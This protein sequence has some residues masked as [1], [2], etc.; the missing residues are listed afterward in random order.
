MTN[1][2][3]LQRAVKDI[4][5]VQSDA[6]ISASPF[7]LLEDALRA[8]REAAGFVLDSDEIHASLAKKGYVVV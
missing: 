8:V 6:A 4:E 5:I 1:R 3:R 2:E 7:C